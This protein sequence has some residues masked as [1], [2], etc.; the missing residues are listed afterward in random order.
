MKVTVVIVNYCGAQDTIRCVA[1]LKAMHP[2][3]EWIVVVDNAS[4]D[5]SLRTLRDSALGFELVAS[6]INAGFAAGC[7]A[8]ARAALARGATHLWFLNPDCVPDSDALAQMLRALES[9]QPRL[10]GA[11]LVDGSGR[12]CFAGGSLG[13]RTGYLRHWRDSSGGCE[14][15]ERRTGFLTGAC[16]LMSRDTYALLGPMPEQQ[17]LYFEDADWCYRATRL[18][19][20][21]VVA[22]AARVMHGGG[23]SSGGPRA[24]RYVYYNTRNAIAFY[25]SSS[26]GLWMLIAIC[27]ALGVWLRRSLRVHGRSMSGLRWFCRGVLDGLNGKTGEA[28][29]RV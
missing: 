16:M 17:F 24:G 6:P 25:R 23:A 1:A 7:N 19:I 29:Q 3:P 9:P 28:P 21:L 13:R 4:P 11:V 27:G 22:L 15:G 12:V 5:D 8:G 14:G 26:P 20:V 10:V 2:A 18:G